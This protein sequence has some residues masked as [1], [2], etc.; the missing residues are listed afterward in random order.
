MNENRPLY[1]KNSQ[2]I[3]LLF[4]LAVK[5]IIIDLPMWAFSRAVNLLGSAPGQ[6]M[7]IFD[8]S[9]KKPTNGNGE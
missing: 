5:P 6:V 7:A 2:I 9:R 8:R 4:K 1:P 3:I